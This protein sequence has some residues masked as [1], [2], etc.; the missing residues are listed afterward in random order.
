[1]VQRRP[2]APCA[3]AGPPL[4]PPETQTLV[5]AVLRSQERG[6][7]STPTLDVDVHSSGQTPDSTWFPLYFCR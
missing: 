5:G 1:M 4:P 7:P 2:W 3:P 6:P